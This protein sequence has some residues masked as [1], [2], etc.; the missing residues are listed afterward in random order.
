[1]INQE[2]LNYI[3][4]QSSRGISKEEIKNNL[5]TSGW[6]ETDINEAFALVFDPVPPPPPK[7]F[8]QPDSGSSVLPQSSYSSET[9]FNQASKSNPVKI[10]ILAFIIIIIAATVSLAARIWDPLWSPFRP[11][12]EKVIAEMILKQEELKTFHYKTETRIKLEDTIN[13]L[14]VSMNTDAQI[15]G[16]DPDNL[17]LSSNFD[18]VMD[19]EGMQFSLAGQVKSIGEISYFNLTTIPVALQPIFILSGVNVDEVRNQWIKFDSESI[20]DLMGESLILEMEDDLEKEKEREEELKEAIMDIFKNRKIYLLK[21]ELADKKIGNTG[22]Y[23]YLV[24]LNTEEIKIIIPQLLDKISEI[25]EESN[26]S[27]LFGARS[28]AKDARVKANIAQIRSMAELIYSNAGYSQLSCDYSD[29]R[30]FGISRLC[31]DISDTVGDSPTIFASYNNYCVF[32]RSTI[33]GYYFCVDSRSGTIRTTE[34]PQ[35]DGFCNGRTFVCPENVDIPEEAIKKAAEEELMKGLDEFFE[36]TGEITAELWIGKKDNYL[37]KIKI[38]KELDLN[39]F[40]EKET[41]KVNIKIDM[42]FS[43]FNKPVK[44]ESPE[45][46]KSLEDIFGTIF[47]Q[48]QFADSNKRALD[49]SI[50][51]NMSQLRAMSE[52]HYINQKPYSYTNF[53]TSEDIDFIKEDIIARGGKNFSCY[54]QTGSGVGNSYCIKV[55]LNSGDWFC[56][57]SDLRAKQ[58][59][60]NPA[61]TTSIG[62]TCKCE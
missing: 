62:R 41:G 52:I 6:S 25:L 20:N 1:M 21:K 15:D 37:Y 44:I 27:G 8:P 10:I 28:R 40:D 34:N 12:P 58:Y 26:G 50:V 60:S 14:N 36:K 23:H 48:S 13:P 49:A 43:D 22:V 29:N 24:S 17:K 3:K 4:Q 35:R 47:S 16:T 7:P 38:E 32:A 2:L 51:A 61:C 59:I 30:Y 5:I 18:I 57:D 33:E 54:V 55:Q 53:C 56:I 46:Y 39:K 19:L 31:E 11:D 45:S 42:E 9:H